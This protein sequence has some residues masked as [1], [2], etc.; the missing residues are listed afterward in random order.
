MTNTDQQQLVENVARQIIV[1][2]APEELPLFRATSKAY[3]KNPAQVLKEQQSEDELLGFGAG[4]AV[5]LLT[6]YVLVIMTEVVKFVTDEVQKALADESANVISDLVKKLFKRL[7]TE[8]K[9]SAEQL[10]QVRKVAYEN[11]LR[12]K[13]PDEQANLLA[14]AI[15][16]A[17]LP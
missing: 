6:P 12:L 10:I 13:L 11:A 8:E 16:G 15:K 9:L 14:D 4:E 3:F 7:P 2:T 5:T 17:L 1:Q